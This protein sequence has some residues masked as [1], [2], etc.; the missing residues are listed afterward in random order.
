[1]AEQRGLVPPDGEAALRARVAQLESIVQTLE[2][3]ATLGDRDLEAVRKL[4]R[5]LVRENT[6]LQREGRAG[7]GASAGH[8]PWD[9]T[10][11]SLSSLRRC[12]LV[13]Q[14]R[15]LRADPR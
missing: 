2:S 5:D 11:G 1:M 8:E 6:R 4:N 10:G 15:R 7:N 9:S 14:T 12:R 3:R 13:C